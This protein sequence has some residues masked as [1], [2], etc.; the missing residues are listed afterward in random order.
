[1][2]VHK[3]IRSYVLGV[4]P[5]LMLG[6]VEERDITTLGPTSQPMWSMETSL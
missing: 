5:S 3:S 6:S 4:A 1:M 2:R